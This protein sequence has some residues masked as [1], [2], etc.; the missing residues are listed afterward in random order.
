MADETPEPEYARPWMARFID[1]FA[2]TGNVTLSARGCGL[3]SKRTIYEA[4]DRD[5]VFAAAMDDARESAIQVLEAE[6]RNRAMSG[7]D[8][9]L[10][11]L[12]KAQ[13]PEMYRESIRID[14]RREA[15]RMAADL[16]MSA[17]EIIAEAERILTG[18]A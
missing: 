17:D 15:E 14:V 11:F 1:L 7:S 13:R 2:S 12:L 3:R 4:R 10:I 8:V 9:L 5:P 16:G 18:G 6:A